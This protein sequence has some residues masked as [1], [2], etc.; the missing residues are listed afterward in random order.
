[1]AMPA[2]ACPAL[3]RRAAQSVDNHFPYLP[4]V[5][6]PENNPCIQMVIRIATKIYSFS[7]AHCQ[8]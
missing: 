1:M 7:L 8:P 4:T 6:N 3:Q 2:S 5:T